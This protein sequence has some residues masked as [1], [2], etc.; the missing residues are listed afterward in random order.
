[1]R[2]ARN[3]TL[4]SWGNQEK[5]GTRIPW[6]SGPRWTQ[7]KR[8]GKVREKTSFSNRR[9]REDPETEWQGW[10]SN[11][12][13][14]QIHSIPSSTSQN[15]SW[16]QGKPRPPWTP[17]ADESHLILIPTA[18]LWLWGVNYPTRVV[19]NHR[20][21]PLTQGWSI[22]VLGIN[23]AQRRLGAT[24]LSLKWLRASPGA[25]LGIPVG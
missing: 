2:Q 13:V 10:K 5:E 24:V 22:T 4:L 3:K 9:S 23:C 12:T 21:H 15:S 17:K 20:I 25:G 19:W 16:T 14:L 18:L 7:P 6:A 1:M 8:G 11:L